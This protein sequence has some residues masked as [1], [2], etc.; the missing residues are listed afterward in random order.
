[1]GG[2]GRCLSALLCVGWMV[3]WM[4]CNR[5]LIHCSARALIDPLLGGW[6]GSLAT[7]GEKSGTCG[8]RNRDG[9]N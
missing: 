9:N 6:G 2:S 3:R 5:K 8:D 7:H 4:H 1:M